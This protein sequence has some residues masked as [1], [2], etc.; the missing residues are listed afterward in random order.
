MPSGDLAARRAFGR[1]TDAVIDHPLPRRVRYKE[2]ETGLSLALRLRQ[3]DGRNWRAFSRATGLPVSGLRMSE[4]LDALSLASTV[5]VEQFRPWTP[6]WFGHDVKVLGHRLDRSRFLRLNLRLCPLCMSED[7]ERSEG[8]ERP[9]DAAY[10]RLEWCL[11][12]V[13]GCERH[14]VRLVTKCPRCGNRPKWNI[15]RID[16]CHCGASL[17]AVRTERM[18]DSEAEVLSLLLDRLHGRIGHS[19]LL[20]ETADVPLPD[21]VNLLRMLGEVGSDVAAAAKPCALEIDELGAVLAS[22]TEALSDLPGSFKALLDRIF[23][24]RPIVACAA[25]GAYGFPLVRWMRS[26][27]PFIDVL[28]PI[29]DGH[30]REHGSHPARRVG[31]NTKSRAFMA[32]ARR[33]TLLSDAEVERLR[34]SVNWGGTTVPTR[35]EV[36]ETLA[37]GC[38]VLRIQ[39]SADHIGLPWRCFNE[40]RLAGAI[41][42]CWDWGL[43]NLFYRSELDSIVR[44]CSEGVRVFEAAPPGYLDIAKLARRRK[45]PSSTL[46]LQ[47]LKGGL[48]CDGLLSGKRGLAA[49]FFDGAGERAGERPGRKRYPVGTL[50][51]GPTAE[52][53]RLTAKQ[54]R[55]VGDA[56]LLELQL[57]KKANFCTFE[58][59][60]AFDRRYVS[61]TAV[62]QGV[63]V[64]AQRARALLARAAV[65]PILPL[66]NGA[67]YARDDVDR[68][69]GR[70]VVH[71]LPPFAD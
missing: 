9:E 33:R 38:E 29:F 50:S 4:A 63:G 18:T 32:R 6:A 45:V 12:F 5:P 64:R 28:R 68:A 37:P 56:K 55:Q 34:R 2:Q 1:E 47:L 48:V 26:D 10:L 53:L 58:A 71:L 27:R 21:L 14:G 66:R 31:N 57:S 23:G 60:A 11:A 51:T 39:A 13:F 36:M 49:V 24:D 25:V 22:G 40:L 20:Q 30:A 54:C 17:L 3:R 8:G 19:S 44:R 61:L 62:A 15:G 7:M 35:L 41:E 69:F 16:S 70:G 42:P 65:I 59:I 43:M 52:L 46:L 67:V